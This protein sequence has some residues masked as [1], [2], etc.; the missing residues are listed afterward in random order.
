MGNTVLFVQ[1]SM[2]HLV[3]YVLIP[4]MSVCVSKPLACLTCIE[5]VL[6][7]LRRISGNHVNK[8]IHKI[9]NVHVYT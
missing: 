1:I 6:A 2:Y 3:A 4:C 8:L 7:V 9:E 5:H